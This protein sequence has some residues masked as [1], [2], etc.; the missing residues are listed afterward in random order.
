MEENLQ[1]AHYGE[2]REVNATEEEKKIF[3]ILCEM[4]GE[5]LELIRRSD[6]YVTACLGRCDLARIKFTKRAKWVM[7]PYA[8][9]KQVKHRIMVPEDVTEFI[10]LIAKTL[11]L[12]RR[13][14]E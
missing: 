13:C 11:E 9:A 4:T 10:G 12:I 1:F 5:P 6:S 2:K 3:E 8:E 14:S 7:F